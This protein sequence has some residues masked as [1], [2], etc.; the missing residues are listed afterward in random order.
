[1]CG[2]VERLRGQ[3]LPRGKGGM[4]KLRCDLSKK[5]MFHTFIAALVKFETRGKVEEILHVFRESMQYSEEQYSE[6]QGN[7]PTVQQHEYVYNVPDVYLHG[8]VSASGSFSTHL[9][10]RAQIQHMSKKRWGDVVIASP[11]PPPFSPPRS[12]HRHFAQF[13]FSELT[14]VRLV[15]PWFC[16][17]F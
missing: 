5:P 7:Q 11:L 17:C 12:V 10:C 9:L 8:G 1:M 3:S 14:T 16:R 2:V 6:E 13:D 4:G 15:Y